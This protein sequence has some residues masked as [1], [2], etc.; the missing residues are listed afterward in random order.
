MQA[1]VVHPAVP[2]AEL[3]AVAQVPQWDGSVCSATS[4]PLPAL[5]SQF[6]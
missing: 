5:L 1:P 4:Q 6:P 2:L 3:Q